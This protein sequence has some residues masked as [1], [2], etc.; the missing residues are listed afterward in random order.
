MF[1]PTLT[2]AQRTA[3]LHI[4]QDVTLQ[5]LMLALT[6]GGA[7]VRVIGGAV[8]DA[9]SGRP[10]GDID[11]AA[12]LPPEQVVAILSQNNIGHAPTGI[13]H[14]TITAIIDHRG[15]EITSLRRDVATDG[16]RATVTYTDNWQEDAAR[17]DFTINALSLD[18]EG[19]VYDYTDGLRDL[20]QKRVRF[21]GDAKT[22]IREDVL[23]ILRFYRFQSAFGGDVTDAPARTACKNLSSLLPQLSAER[24][25]R[26]IAKLLATAD[27]T[28]IWQMML[29]DGVLA[30]WATAA[31]HTDALRNLVACE[32]KY[33]AKGF[34]LR[35]L[36]ALLACDAELAASTAQQLKCSNREA[37]QLTAIA[38]LAASWTGVPDA[39]EIRRALYQ[40][41]DKDGHKVVRH[42]LFIATSR[43]GSDTQAAL[44]Q[45]FGVVEAWQAPAFPL[46]GQDLLKLGQPAGPQMGDLLRAVEAWWIAGD[47]TADKSA[48]LAKARELLNQFP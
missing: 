41:R 45:A 8:R 29:D 47:F 39:K 28:P 17:R 2:D 22:R 3:C 21:I 4:L 32:M 35:R 12:S 16:R 27:P 33:E 37:E 48:C 15:F 46:Q 7:T 40:Q 34:A 18:A 23:R 14:G 10:I 19:T 31:R 42:A 6:Q 13:D 26:E 9:L 43:A 36:A 25:W 11:L 24:V 30:H 38:R 5:R 20:M 1:T 44:S